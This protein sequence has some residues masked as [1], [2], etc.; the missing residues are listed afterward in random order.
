MRLFF[1]FLALN[2]LFSFTSTSQ[3]SILGKWKTL[4]DN[5]GEVKSIIELFERE[6]LVF[7]VIL[8]TFP[9]PGEDPN[10][11]CTK[12]PADD[13][14]YNKTILGMEILREMKRSGQEYSNG[15]ILDP[16]VGKIYKCKIWL[17]SGDLKVRGYWGPFWRTQT[18]K[19]VG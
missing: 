4:D 2:F 16:E 9:K 7:G 15:D 19:R 11:V 3:N 12:C 18:W 17:E 13:I 14:R 1:V 6:G 8:K 10:P 5:T